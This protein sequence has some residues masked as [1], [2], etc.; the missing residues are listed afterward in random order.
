[1]AGIIVVQVQIARI[2]LLRAQHVMTAVPGPT[3]ATVMM[4]VLP[5]LMEW[6]SVR[7]ERT[8]VIVPTKNLVRVLAYPVSGR[9][10]VAHP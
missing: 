6:M 7:M 10:I 3:T 8:V 5:T 1:M 4:T 2:A 9:I